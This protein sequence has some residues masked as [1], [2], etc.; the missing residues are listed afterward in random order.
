MSISRKWNSGDIVELDLPMEI[1]R[2]ESHPKV[3]DN[4]G[5]VAITRGPIVY[6]FEGVDNDNKVQDVTLP[7]EAKFTAEHRSD[8]LGGVT[9]L[10]GV[11]NA[12]RTI[13]A[14]PYYAWDHREPGPMAVW[15]R[16]DG[17]SSKPDV[18]DP[19]WQGK[20]YRTLNPATLA[21]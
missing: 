8:L 4:R 13:T 14:I 16:Q 9:A 5:R 7:R 6:C 20:L 3:E 10:K 19:S 1:Q 15:V 18:D 12:G 21:K 11:D 17:K 2:I